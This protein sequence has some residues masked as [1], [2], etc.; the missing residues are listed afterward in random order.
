MKKLIIAFVLAAG[1]RSTTTTSTSA[2]P[3]PVIR[4]NESGA[5]DPEAAVR[6]FMTAVEQQDLQLMGA[7]FGDVDGPARDR[8]SRTELEQRES[9][10]MCYLKHDKYAIIGDAPVPGG[11]RAYAVNLTLGTATH[12]ATFELVQGPGR[13]W[14]VKSI[15]DFAKLQEFCQRR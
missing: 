9:I 10:M 8:L 4:G 6:G 15:P 3:A 2:T 13:R 14:Y 12:S 7:L 5:A 1:C 11:T